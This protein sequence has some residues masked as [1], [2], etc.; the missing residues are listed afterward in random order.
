MNEVQ[1]LRCPSVR[2]RVLKF[3][4]LIITCV[5]GCTHKPKTPPDQN[6]IRKRVNVT[7][8]LKMGIHSYLVRWYVPN[9]PLVCTR[10]FVIACFLAGSYSFDNA[11]YRS[12][13]DTTSD[14]YKR[15][16]KCHHTKT[17]KKPKKHINLLRTT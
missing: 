7:T 5:C 9:S 6:K 3:P 1:G 11:K 10:F 16:H 2:T 15:T 4:G 8:P 14:L 12:R 17:K 13:L